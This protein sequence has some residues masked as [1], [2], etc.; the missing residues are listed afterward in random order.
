MGKYTNLASQYNYT[1]IDISEGEDIGFEAVIPKFPNLHTVGDSPDQLNK[2]MRILIE[3]EIELCVK[4][5][6]PIPKPD[7]NYSYSGRF[8]LRVEPEI[9]ERLIHLSAAEGSSLNKYINRLIEEK[10]GK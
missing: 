6:R 4:N 7:K 3:E 8:I 1:I 10:I 5:G 9:H 2:A